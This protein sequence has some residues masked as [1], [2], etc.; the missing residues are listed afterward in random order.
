M[1]LAQETTPFLRHQRHLASSAPHQN[2]SKPSMR[3]VS[4]ASRSI[5][6]SLRISRVEQEMN[7]TWPPP[8]A[9]VVPSMMLF[10]SGEFRK[11]GNVLQSPLHRAAMSGKWIFTNRNAR[12]L[13]Q[14][15]F[16]CAPQAMLLRDFGC[17]G[18]FE[19]HQRW[20]SDPKPTVWT[21]VIK[22][23]KDLTLRAPKLIGMRWCCVLFFSPIVLR[24]ILKLTPQIS[25]NSISRS[26]DGA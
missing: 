11:T 6:G 15:G 9:I 1:T 10:P 16:R 22:L 24:P 20:I 7:R 8:I 25:T 4:E 5:A 17:V 14:L 21:S 23:I 2:W 13:L 3:V 18:R 19:S 12:R 26:I